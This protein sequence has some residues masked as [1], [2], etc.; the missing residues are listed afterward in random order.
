M[1]P[2]YSQDLYTANITENAPEGVVLFD[3]FSLISGSEKRS[4]ATPV[5]FPGV[6]GGYHWREL[7]QVSFL[8]RQKLVFCRDKS[9]CDKRRVLSRQTRV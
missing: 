1:D 7:P 9:N 8:S 3:F 4:L 2:N 5:S 6:V